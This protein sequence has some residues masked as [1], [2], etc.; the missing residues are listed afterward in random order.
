MSE[1][2]AIAASERPATAAT[3]VADLRALGVE[4]GMTL[5]VHSALSRLGFVAGGAHTVVLALLEAVGPIGT[6]MMPTHSTH[7]SEPS[8]WSNP[9]VPESWFQ[10][11]RDEMPAY[12]PA[13]TP[14][15]SMGAIVECFRH[16]PGVMRSAHPCV[17]A[18]A[19]G[20]DAEILV[21]E[22]ALAHALG[23]G[24][25][26]ARLYDLDGHVLLLGVDHGNN[27][28]LHL[29]EYRSPPPGGHE[30]VQYASAIVDDG[31][32]RWVTYDSIEEDEEDFP[33]L[34]EA[35]AETGLERRGPVGA[36]VGRLMRSRDIVSF[37]VEWLRVNR[38]GG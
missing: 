38:H 8:E 14:T 34:G 21:S 31:E 10:P 20:P 5:M 28:S 13:L 7:L 3:L 22:H 2:D 18:A 4:P 19:V 36:G 27:T 9:P 15:R 1:A 23:E 25:P 6:L 11:L 26:Q 37:G 29:S 12:D 32:R 35:F 16:V 30:V 24:S 17:S 33:Q